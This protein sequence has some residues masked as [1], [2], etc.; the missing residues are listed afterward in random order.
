MTNSEKINFKKYLLAIFLI[1][2]IISV[3]WLSFRWY[4]IHKE[5]KVSE[6]YLISEKI[7][8]KEIKS[9]DEVID[10]FSEAPNTYFILLSYTGNEEVYNL[11]KDLAK[12]IEKH[13]LEDQIYYLDITDIKDDDNVLDKINS[14]LGLNTD[15]SKKVTQ[16][17]TIIYY[18]D[19]VAIDIIKRQD[20]N[21]MNSGDFEKMLD[22]NKVSE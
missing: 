5:K 17:P 2:L 6:S 20:N 1:I 16:I 12:V 8:T 14:S 19:G 13:K 15:N 18:K 4:A 3:T 11:E 9:I 22:I 21:I 10:V 7:L